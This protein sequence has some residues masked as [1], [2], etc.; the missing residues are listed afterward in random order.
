MKTSFRYIG[1]LL[2]LFGIS[3]GHSQGQS[4]IEKSFDNIEKLEI[5]GGSISLSY[6]GNASQSS[7]EVTADLGDDQNGDKNLIFVTVGN[8]LKISYQKTGNW[9]NNKNKR[10]IHITGPEVIMLKAV[11]SSGKMHIK[12]VASELTEL[13]ASS[14]I[15]HIEDISGNLRLAGSSGKIE[16]NNVEGDVDCKMT[17]GIMDLEY[18]KGNT[19][20]SSSS[21]KITARHVAGELNVKITSGSVDLEDISTLG[22]LKLSSGMMNAKKVGFGPNTSFSGSSGMFKVKANALLDNYNYDMNAGSGMVKVGKQSSSDHLLIDHGA[23]Y[24]IKGNIGSGMISIE[25]Y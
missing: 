17:S 5:Q 21:G 12:G 22:A 19:S 15:I 9:N 1:F 10:Y 23:A 16:V 8:T 2:F 6:E 7:I 3:L 4:K 20:L 18:I 13:K 25:K 11:N 24:T 14:G